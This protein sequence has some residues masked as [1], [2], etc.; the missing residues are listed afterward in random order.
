MHM[1]ESL[2]ARVGRETQ[3]ESRPTLA[4]KVFGRK[5]APERQKLIDQPVAPAQ[6]PALAEIVAACEV[7]RS[8]PSRLQA[9][10]ADSIYRL[11]T[12][13]PVTD[14]AQLQEALRCLGKQPDCIPGDTRLMKNLIATNAAIGPDYQER[15]ATLSG[16]IVRTRQELDAA[17]AAEKKAELTWRE[18]SNR[19][20]AELLAFPARAEL[21]REHTWM[22]CHPEA[23][24]YSRNA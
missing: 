10:Y 11:A 5:P 24:R 23:T 19:Y 22:A 13:E 15:M 9:F 6:S 4:E 14:T 21:L 8:E 7:S 20:K 18:A 12:G 2:L 1:V 3:F 17:K 16:E